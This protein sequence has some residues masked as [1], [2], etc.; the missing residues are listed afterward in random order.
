M[1]GYVY[2]GTGFEHERGSGKTVVFPVGVTKLSTKVLA[3]PRGQPARLGWGSPMERS[4][5]RADDDV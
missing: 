2:F 3:M 4:P 5:P 1:A